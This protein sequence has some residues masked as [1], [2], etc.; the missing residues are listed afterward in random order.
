[1]TNSATEEIP[2]NTRHTQRVLVRYGAILVLLGLISGIT[3]FFAAVPSA[4]L[5]AHN[6]GVIEGTMLIGLAGAW[7][8]LRASTRVLAAIKYT[9]VIGLYANW[10]GVQLA[11]F[12]SAKDLFIVTGGAFPAGAAPW[13]EGIVFILLNLS[14]L[15]IATCGLIVMATRPPR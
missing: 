3:T 9:A 5:S 11:A 2:A 6:I 12:W 7:P 4:A 14:G 8:A 10:I 15:V 1:M 13:Q